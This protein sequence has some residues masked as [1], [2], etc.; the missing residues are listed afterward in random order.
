MFVVMVWQAVMHL[1]V[2]VS[3]LCVTV[4]I[5]WARLRQFKPRSL[6][7]FPIKFRGNWIFMVL[8]ACLSFPV[9]D[10]LALQSQVRSG[11]PLIPTASLFTADEHVHKL[12]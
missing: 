4:G 1:V 10:W 8:F 3:E 2:D 11:F 6:G 5:L 12:L 9:V 7:L